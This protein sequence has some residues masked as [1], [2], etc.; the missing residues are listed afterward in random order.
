MGD[1]GANVTIDSVEV[2]ENS[3][4]QSTVDGL[5]GSIGLFSVSDSEGVMLHGLDMHS[6][7]LTASRSGSGTSV[8]GGHLSLVD[9]SGNVQYIDLR[10]NTSTADDDVRGGGVMVTDPSGALH[11]SNAIIAGNTLVSNSGYGM[12]GG[13]VVQ[14]SAGNGALSVTNVTIHGNSITAA[15]EAR[16]AGLAADLDG[17]DALSVVN[18]AIGASVAV[19]DPVEGEAVYVSGPT[20][21]TTWSYN[22]VLDLVEDVSFFG[23]ADPT[24]DE[25]GNITGDPFYAQ[26]SR[27]DA[28]D[29]DLTYNSR[30]VLED[31]GDPEIFDA[32]GSRSDIGA[33]GGPGSDGW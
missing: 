3:V 33:Y 9:T 16:G 27:E 15:T 32:D 18:T 29:W 17:V 20:S 5:A 23:I 14:N 26:D 21:I 2:V 31:A 7:D 12:G 8:A 11:V 4:S 13:I 24:D 10:S 6:N 25:N 19:G 28:T 1:L 30:S 22:A